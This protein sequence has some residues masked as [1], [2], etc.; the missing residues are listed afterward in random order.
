MWWIQRQLEK[1]NIFIYI[2]PY[3][4]KMQ[5]KEYRKLTKYLRKISTVK[6]NKRNINTNINICKATV[7]KS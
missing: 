2:A 7:K 6:S 3:I 5:L 4:L 1:T